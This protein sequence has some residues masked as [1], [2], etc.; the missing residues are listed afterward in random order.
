MSEIENYGNHSL[1][2]FQ[3]ADHQYEG[4]YQSR[5]SREIARM[6]NNSAI[7]VARLLKR[8]QIEAERLTRQFKL[9]H[10]ESMIFKTEVTRAMDDANE[11][12][13]YSD[14][15][16]SGDP[17]KTEIMGSIINGWKHA[18]VDRLTYRHGGL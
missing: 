17:R 12:I 4:M 3:S 18:T 1:E 15:L 14:N 13:D 6:E 2:R 16:A 5:T 10:Y 8:Q 11:L 9:D 7:E